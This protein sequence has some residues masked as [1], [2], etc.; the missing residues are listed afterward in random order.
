MA[1]K[2]QLAQRANTEN[3]PAKTTGDTVATLINR[4]RNDI[5]KGLPEHFKLDRL[6]RL[7]IGA[8]NRTPNLAQ[9]SE[10]SLVYAFITSTQL[11]LELNTP[12]GHAYLVPY[13]RSVK[14]GND[15]IKVHEA[16][17][18]IGYQGIIELARRS[19]QFA[20]IQ[21]RHTFKNDKKI[22]RYG[23]DSQFILEP[24][25]GDPGEF[26]GVFAYYRLKDGGEDCIWWSKER[27]EEH[28]RQYSKSWQADKKQFDPKSAWGGNFM[29]M[30]PVPVIK[31]LLKF[32]PKSIEISLEKLTPENISLQEAIT[33]DG[34]IRRSSEEI[35]YAESGEVFDIATA[36]EAP[37][38]QPEPAAKPKKPATPK[39]EPAPE[40]VHQEQA[41]A[42]D[43][44]K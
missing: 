14:Q 3:L 28:A 5:I 33:Y 13:S 26:D 9:C 22:I 39:A 4:Y 19:G 6:E 8:I 37:T 2:D 34:T 24:A 25:L 20:T 30:A 18:Q 44:F 43:M 31:Q 32:A 42:A 7:A 10:R 16:Q 11:G 35:E 41:D 12:L 36:E 40:K 38:P 15:W 27:I 29:G 1:L 21:V 17:F 23:S